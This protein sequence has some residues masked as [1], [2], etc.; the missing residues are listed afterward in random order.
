MSDNENQ[1]SSYG[2]D[3]IVYALIPIGLAL[4]P[5]ILFGIFAYVVSGK[6]GGYPKDLTR[7]V[8]TNMIDNK[9]QLYA[10]NRKLDTH[11]KNFKRYY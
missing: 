8:K 5:L 6:P 1:E 4:S 11:F 3:K 7:M 10:I 2:E 9:R